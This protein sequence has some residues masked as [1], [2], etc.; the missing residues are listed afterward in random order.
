MAKKILKLVSLFIL[1]LFIG[2]AFLFYIDVENTELV[3]RKVVEYVSAHFSLDISIDGNLD[4]S[5]GNGVKIDVSALTVNSPTESI[6]SMKGNGLTLSRIGEEPYRYVLTVQSLKII[7][8]SGRKKRSITDEFIADTLHVV[9]EK[10]NKA[11][12]GGNVYEI[13]INN[14]SV[15][16]A[17]QADRYQNVYVNL[18]KEVARI[19][20]CLGTCDRSFSLTAETGK[21]DIGH[22]V[23][24]IKLSGDYISDNLLIGYDVKGAIDGY[25]LSYD[26]KIVVES[27]GENEEWNSYHFDLNRDS[28]LSIL[29]SDYS[30]GRLSLGGEYVI[31]YDDDFEFL[32]YLN[33]V[34][35]A[36]NGEM[37]FQDHTDRIDFLSV[38]FMLESERF[39]AGIKTEGVAG[40][41]FLNLAGL[42]GEAL[43]KKRMNPVFVENL[44]GEITWEIEPLRIG[45]EDVGNLRLKFDGYNRQEF[46]SLESG[47]IYSGSVRLT[48]GYSKDQETEEILHEINVDLKG[49]DLFDIISSVKG[50]S[51]YVT[52]GRLFGF[53]GLEAEG[54]EIVQIANSLSGEILLEVEDMEISSKLTSIFTST[55]QQALTELAKDD[56]ATQEKKPNESITEVQCG[57]SLLFVDKGLFRS[58]NETVLVTENTNIFLSGRYSLQSGMLDMGIIPN[59]KAFFDVSTSSLVKFFRITGPLDDLAISL[60]SYELLKTGV[61]TTISYFTGPLGSIAFGLL[62]NGSAD[63]ECNRFLE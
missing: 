19:S 7:P 46:L 42:I 30:Q 35:K 23:I 44:E 39:G 56:E 9:L 51:T 40:K 17:E 20:A 2:A 24:G 4:F 10:I 57:R 34:T 53:A 6:F 54:T 12:F 16:N 26:S 11:V 5:V 15:E 41:D 14:I 60:D 36:W 37:G 18:S 45:N 52:E 25:Q 33:D 29:T 49:V 31:Q 1:L 48:S 43:R 59:T 22:N 38:E 62:G 47:E 61:S 32:S 55:L 13:T 50:E 8:Q 27:K 28:G 3:K 21:Q 58:D 63:I